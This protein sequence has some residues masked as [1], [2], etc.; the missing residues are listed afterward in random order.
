MKLED[1]TPELQ[2]KLEQCATPEE[3]VKLVKEEGIELPDEEL[4]GVA[5]GNIFKK[6]FRGIANHDVN[7]AE[8]IRKF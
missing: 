7:D 2:E 3:L 4:E 6:L 1:L 5:G 8:A